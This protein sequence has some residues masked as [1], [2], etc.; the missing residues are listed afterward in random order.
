I[1]VD[2]A[3]NAYVMG[4]NSDNAFKITLDEDDDGV[5]NEIDVC[6]NTPAG[7]PVACDGRPLRDCNGDCLFDAADIQCIV[8]ELLNQ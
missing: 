5:P 4:Q 6:P 1:A 3:G 7:M 8:D 2:A